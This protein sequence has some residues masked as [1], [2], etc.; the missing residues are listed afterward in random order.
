MF[1][2]KLKYSMNIEIKF[3][4]TEK[5]SSELRKAAPDSL[6]R[7]SAKSSGCSGTVYGLGIEESSD[8]SDFIEEISG[9]KFVI[10]RSSLMLLDEVTLDW[11]SSD[12][13]EG[14]KFLD[15]KPTACCR[16]GG[17]S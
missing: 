16:K 7:V 8:P 3:N 14:F 1:P 4:V 6:V 2:D 17:C 13:R 12:G 10:D 5:A 9:V 11:H 15:S